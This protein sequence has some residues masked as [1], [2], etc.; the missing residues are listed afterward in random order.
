MILV[1]NAGSSSL[2]VS[3]F[4]TDLTQIAD[5][6]VSDI[7]ANASL[8]LNK[9]S[10]L[11]DA[12]D[13]AVALAQMMT[14]LDD[15]GHKITDITAVAHRV[16]HGGTY[17]SAP[18]RVSPEVIKAIQD[19]IPLAPL[20]N[21]V[22]L[23]GIEALAKSHP[24]LPQFAS[25]DTAFHATNPAI[26]TRYAIPDAQFAAGIQRYG[27]HGSSYAS[28]VTEFGA[29]LPSRL[30]ALHLGNGASL[31]AIK[32]G[33]SVASS[34]G[35]S[36][37][38]G[39]VMGTRCG[40]IDGAAVLRIADDLGIAA[41]DQLLNKQ[42]GLKGLAGDNNMKTLMERDDESARFAVDHFCY[43]A[44]RQVGSAIIAMDGL[45]AVAF[46]GGIGENAAP[47]RDKIMAH[48]TCFG[49]VPVH[50]IAADEE[51]Q[52]ARDARLLMGE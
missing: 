26:A 17:F 32:D 11:L 7:G 52:I 41:A 12:P 21:P 31:C 37:M 33:K 2:K 28:M 10:T 14:A 34:M 18:A 49:D 20:H 27:F 35:Y 40:D 46:T 6:M 24:H 48:L 5:G 8:K 16:V 1:I 38:S 44:A 3:L 25:F 36:P 51:K 9:Q 13:H 39:L 30:L 4:Q 45:D 19:C 42:S 29:D 15:A 50:V 23:I 47:I 43:W 22:N